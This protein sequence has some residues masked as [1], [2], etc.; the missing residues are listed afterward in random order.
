MT[1]LTLKIIAVV[2]LLTAILVSPGWIRDVTKE[3]DEKPVQS[4]VK[5]QNKVITGMS[6]ENSYSS[7][8]NSKSASRTCLLYY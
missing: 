7:L 4:V 6:L 8:Y 1:N 2:L 5:N 3:A